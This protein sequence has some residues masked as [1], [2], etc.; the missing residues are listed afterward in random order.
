M[1]LIDR[2]RAIEEIQSYDNNGFITKPTSKIPE[3]L[4]EKELPTIQALSLDDLQD[5]REEI[6]SQVVTTN[7]GIFLDLEEV[8]TILYKY[9]AKAKEKS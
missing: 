8:G 3:M 9:I 6:L 7:D 1:E 4:S 2:Q 5:M